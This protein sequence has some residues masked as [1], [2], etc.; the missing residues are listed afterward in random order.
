M[1]VKLKIIAAISCLFILV[2]AYFYITSTIKEKRAYNNG[3]EKGLEYAN[4][5]CAN[6]AIKAKEL[7]DEKLQSHLEE[8]QKQYEEVN[9][10]HSCKELFSVLVPSECLL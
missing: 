1:I 4:N 5:Q 8:V 6:E 9:K 2:I 10:I 3:F 7:A